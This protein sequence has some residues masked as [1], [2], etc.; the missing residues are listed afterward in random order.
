MTKKII[1]GIISLFLLAIIGFVL[2]VIFTL[3]GIGNPVVKYKATRAIRNYVSENYPGN[4]F[5]EINVYYNFKFG[6][7]ASG[8]QSA[9][10]EDTHFTISYRNGEVTDNYENYVLSGENTYRRIELNFDNKIERVIEDRFP[11]QIELCIFELHD[12]E[13]ETNTREILKLNVPLDGNLEL[14]EL[15]NLGF[16]PALTVWYITDE[17]NFDILET[18][19]VETKAL[20]EELNIPVGTYS[21]SLRYPEE[22]REGRF[23][24]HIGVHHMPAELI[25]TETFMEELLKYY[26]EGQ[27]TNKK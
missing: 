4:D 8:V 17:I 1:T 20:M 9:S 16:S 15:S 5:D 27:K 10:S 25:G 11:N 18:K 24:E 6:D 26:E 21:I 19:F 13:K 2:S 23:D 22:T 12:Y 14:S 3:T 7:Y